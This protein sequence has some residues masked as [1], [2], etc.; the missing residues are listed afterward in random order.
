M[1]HQ[2]YEGNYAIMKNLERLVC[3]F[4]SAIV[5]AKNAGEFIKDVK[6][7][8]FPHGYCDDACDLLAQF[9]IECGIRICRVSGTYRDDMSENTQGHV[10]LLTDDQ[11]INDITGD[12]FRY[13]PNFFY[14]DTPVYIGLEDDFHRLFEIDTPVYEH[15]GLDNHLAELVRLSLDD[16][17][18]RKLSHDLDN[19]V[20]YFGEMNELDT[21]DVAPTYQVT[22]LSNVWREDVVGKHLDRKELLNLAPSVRNDYIEVPQVL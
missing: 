7:C 16:E 22:G 19:I 6:L 21:T 10:W 4:R 17:E 14:Y 8:N 3:Q 12:Q 18:I 9:L 15:N 5:D 1:R 20:N 13:D 2:Q 11:N